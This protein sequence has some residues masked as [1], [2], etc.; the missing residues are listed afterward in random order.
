M[1]TDFPAQS[2][3][4][5]LGWRVW[6]VDTDFPAPVLQSPYRESAVEQKYTNPWITAA[7]TARCGHGH[8][9]PAEECTCGV[10]ADPDSEFLSTLIR[11]IDI[12]WRISKLSKPFRLVMG[13]VT[14][15]GAVVLE[16]RFINPEIGQPSPEYRATHAHIAGLWIPGI[17]QSEPPPHLAPALAQRYAAPVTVGFPPLELTVQSQPIPDDIRRVG[18]QPLPTAVPGG[19]GRDLVAAARR[20]HTTEH[21]WRAA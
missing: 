14:L 16:T 6:I 19:L 20:L 3:P 13:R 12:S 10:Y 15:S 21:R 5:L 1:T 11:V 18:D 7:Q 17:V 4:A 2:P 8:T 9:P